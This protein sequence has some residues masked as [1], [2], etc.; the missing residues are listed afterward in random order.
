LLRRFA[1]NDEKHGSILLIAFPVSLQAASGRSP[2]MS[3][4]GLT[5][6][7][8]PITPIRPP[9]PNRPSRELLAR[10]GTNVRVRDWSCPA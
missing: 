3:A 1:R 6:V 8:L 7:R 2:W 5:T 9:R 10:A 4:A